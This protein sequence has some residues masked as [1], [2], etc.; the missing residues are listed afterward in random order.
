VLR[1]FQ[2]GVVECLLD[3]VRADDQQ[4]CFAVVDELAELRPIRAGDASSLVTAHRADGAAD[5]R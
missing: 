3:R 2:P 1:G 4:R 5:E